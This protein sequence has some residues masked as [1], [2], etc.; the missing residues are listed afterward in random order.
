MI[1]SFNKKN[2]VAL[3]TILLSTCLVLAYASYIQPATEPNMRIT[4]GAKALSYEEVRTFL[5]TDP[6][7]QLI[8]LPPN[9]PDS[10]VVQSSGHSADSG[11]V[12]KSYQNG[13]RVYIE[14]SH[15]GTILKEL[16]F[17]DKQSKEVI[18]FIKE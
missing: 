7:S 10:L 18:V 14:K 13:T 8:V 9:N 15:D 11:Y 5:M 12:L 17:H 16:K 4:P 3:G 1:F 2:A 6:G